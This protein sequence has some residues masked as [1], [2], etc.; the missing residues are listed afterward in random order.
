MYYQKELSDYGGT[1][2]FKDYNTLFEL[3]G[4]LIVPMKRLE[5]AFDKRDR[6]IEQRCLAEEKLQFPI[7]TILTKIVLYTFTFA[8]PFLVVFYITANLVKFSSGESL[9]EAYDE[10]AGGLYIVK[11]FFS[12]A[13]SVQSGAAFWLSLGIVLLE[14]FFCFILIPCTTV[15]LPMVVVCST[16][17]TIISI[18]SAK[19]S[20]REAKEIRNEAEK[21]IDILLEQLKIPLEY[22]PK[23]YR[24]ST[25]LE[26][27]YNSYINGRASTL[28]EAIDS[29]DTYLHRKKMEHSQEVLH[30]E[31]LEI[32]R[33]IQYQSIQINTLNNSVDHIKNKVDWL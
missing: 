33:K 5:H 15:L 30:Q 32:L 26:Y 21:Q 10:W 12:W 27:F 17:G 18:F 11:Q 14:F 16:I 24:Y 3:Y 22:V 13:H 28:K 4:A 31:H 25:A 7:L 19:Q 2:I 23:D 6:S 9:L 29:F 1:F 8:I 20:I